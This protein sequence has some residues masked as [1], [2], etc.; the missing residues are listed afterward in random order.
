VLFY[1]KTSLIILFLALISPNGIADETPMIEVLPS[2]KFIAGWSIGQFTFFAAHSCSLSKD[3]FPKTNCGPG[4]FYAYRNYGDAGKSIN[5][6][7]PYSRERFKSQISVGMGG[8][9]K[10]DSPIALY[11]ELIKNNEAIIKINYRR[12]LNAIPG[13]FDPEDSEEEGTIPKAFERVTASVR[14][15]QFNERA[16]DYYVYE[17]NRVEEE[18]KDVIT[19]RSLY[20]AAST[21]FIILLAY[22]TKQ[23][24]PKMAASTKKTANNTKKNFEEKKDTYREWKRDKKIRSIAEDEAI[25]EIV[26]GEIQGRE[27]LRQR[28]SKIVHRAVE[29]GDTKTASRA[30]S[31]LER[32]DKSKEKTDSANENRSE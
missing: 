6:T 18:R 17:R 5:L 26:R 8:F 16:S 24:F 25:R 31:A 29:K 30:L 7:D 21:F 9:N 11:S 2:D 10:L 3:F 4:R 13:I 32:L 12:V 15:E 14:L 22:K 1:T 27:E 28:L 23:Y 19:Q 20:L